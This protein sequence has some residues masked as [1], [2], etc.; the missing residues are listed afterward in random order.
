LNTILIVAAV[1]FGVII[2]AIHN[3]YDTLEVKSISKLES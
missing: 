1:L 3:K 2:L